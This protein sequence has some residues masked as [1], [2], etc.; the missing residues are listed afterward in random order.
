MILPFVLLAGG[1]VV[2]LALVLAGDEDPP[3]PVHEPDVPLTQSVPGSTHYKLVD[4]ILPELTKAAQASGIP[5]GLLVG[6]IAKESGGKL[7]DTT[8]LDER[9][10]FQLMPS[11]SKRLGLDHERLSTDSVYSINAGL[12]LIA[13]Y[14]KDVDALGVAPRG[15][16]Y[17]WRLVKLAHAMGSGAMNKIVGEAQGAGQTGSWQMLEQYALDNNSHFLSL[18][19]H[20]P[21]KWFPFVDAV[22]NVGKPFGFGTDATTVVGGVVYNDIP[23][24]L[25]VLKAKGT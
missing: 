6:W 3:V 23:D 5:L 22:Y 24:P 4:A 10:Y 18:V 14:M 7:S 13:V 17:Y 8:S 25:D 15:S 20:A 2:L 9:G 21:A 1:G 16:S 11:E 19:K 12:L